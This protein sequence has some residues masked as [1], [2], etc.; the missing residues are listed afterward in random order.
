[1]GDL[2]GVLPPTHVPR[3]PKYFSF[4]PLAMRFH[5]MGFM[6]AEHVIM[7]EAKNDINC[8]IFILLQFT[9]T[10]LKMSASS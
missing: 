9:I 4:D 10:T 7:V 2:V 8:P 6:R 3:D 5:K 1:L